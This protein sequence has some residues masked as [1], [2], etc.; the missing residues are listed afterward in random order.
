M[1]EN[2]EIGYAKKIIDKLE[3]NEDIEEFMV[4]EDFNKEDTEE[5]DEEYISEE[6]NEEE[7]DRIESS[8]DEA[9]KTYKKKKR[10]RNT[11]NIEFEFDKK[12]Y[13]KRRRVKLIF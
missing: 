8:E 11:A 7:E 12:I 4:D 2:D 9:S 10:K 5:N 3:Q 6:E 13:T 1:S